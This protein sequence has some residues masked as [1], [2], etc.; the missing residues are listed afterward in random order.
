MGLNSDHL[1]FVLLSRGSGVRFERSLMIGR[2]ELA[3]DVSTLR[4]MLAV[5]GIQLRGE[6]VERLLEEGDGF[7]DPLLRLLGAVQIDS[8][9]ISSYEGATIMHDL[10]EPIP[11]ALRNRYSVVIES[12]S[13]EHVF[14]I[15]QALRNCL[16]M[17][18]D[19]GHFISIGPANN[20]M[21][22]GFYQ[23]SPELYF[24]TLSSE[25]GFRIERIVAKEIFADA[26]WYAVAD[27]AV[28]GRRM[29][30]Q[31]LGHTDLM[32]CARKERT[33]QVFHPVPQQ[34]DD[35][36][37]WAT[38]RG[39][40]AGASFPVHHHLD[41]HGTL[42][43]PRSLRRRL[44]RPVPAGA[45]TMC[46]RLKRLLGVAG[47]AVSH[48]DPTC[49]TRIELPR[50]TD[51]CATALGL[52]D[53]GLRRVLRSTDHRTVGFVALN[54]PAGLSFQIQAWTIHCV[55]SVNRPPSAWHCS[56]VSC[57]LTLR[58]GKT[59]RSEWR[60][61][62]A[63]DFGNGGFLGCPSRSGSALNR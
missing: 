54:T 63:R 9:D 26:P 20:A 60:C 50:L 6:D 25:N 1:R 43:P 24:R 45:K 27:P 15:S 57:P 30:W 46:R 62:E 40:A 55:N 3:V 39:E 4:R 29:E 37:M 18:E 12:G 7:A 8:M 22:H 56:A 17:V 16:E 21:G 31:S 47:R 2:Q 5:G 36:P 38:D 41:R 35:G 48:P 11:L 33:A 49:F 52:S 53:A 14:N 32:V 58:S 51:D 19:G 34:S 28:V 23:F 42:R 59:H 44:W 10:N 13:L 61:Q